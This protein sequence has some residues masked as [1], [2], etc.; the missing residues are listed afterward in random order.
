MITLKTSLNSFFKKLKNRF[1]D[2]WIYIV[3]SH[4]VNIKFGVN[5][6]TNSTF[7][8]YGWKPEVLGEGGIAF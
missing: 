3:E 4:L 7:F 2:I 5:F 1:G 8:S 6:R